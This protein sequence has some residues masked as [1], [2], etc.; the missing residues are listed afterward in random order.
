MAYRERPHKNL[1]KKNGRYT[2]FCGRFVKTEI[3]VG[4]LRNI[5]LLSISDFDILNDHTT[6]I[7]YF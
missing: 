3:G 2:G 7:N 1:F 5:Q 6:F 4:L